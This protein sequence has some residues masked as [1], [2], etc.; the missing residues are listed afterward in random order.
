[1]TFCCLKCSKKNSTLESRNWLN[2]KKAPFFTLIMS[3]SPE[4]VIRGYL[5]YNIMPL[6]FWFNHFFDSRAEIHQIFE[7]SR[8]H[9]EINWPLN[10][11]KYDNMYL[12]LLCFLD[13]ESPE[14]SCRARKVIQLKTFIRPSIICWFV[15][16]DWIFLSK[17]INWDI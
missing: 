16:S 13:M 9:S 6:S 1:M 11:L 8:S 2:W 15:T 17:W 14:G 10:R 3:N 5:T 7:K 4:F 12:A